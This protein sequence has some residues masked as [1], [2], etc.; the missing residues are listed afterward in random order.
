M[1]KDAGR[2]VTMYQEDPVSSAYC[3]LENRFQEVEL[4]AD[5]MFL[6]EEPEL[7]YRSTGGMDSFVIG[8]LGDGFAAAVDLGTMQDIAA[9]HGYH[10]RL[11]D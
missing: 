6:A 5:F 1:G 4:D 9:R 10:P 3:F 11:S 7:R 2:I 8:N